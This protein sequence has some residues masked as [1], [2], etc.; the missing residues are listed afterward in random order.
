MLTFLLYKFRHS[1]TILN[2]RFIII[3]DSA[4]ADPHLVDE[5]RHNSLGRTIIT[6]SKGLEIP[7]LSPV[8]SIDSLLLR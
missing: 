7:Q 3:V 1:I 4:I 8:V 6:H 2:L 5:I